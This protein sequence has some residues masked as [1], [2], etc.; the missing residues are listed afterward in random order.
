M[1][2]ITIDFETASQHRRNSACEL[3][4]TFV[5]NNKIIETKSWLIK[6]YINDFDYFN[7]LLHGITAT[8]V[9]NK[10]EFSEIWDEVKELI[11][12]NLLIAH[13]AAFDF[14]VLRHT[15][16]T[17]SLPYPELDYTCSYIFSKK[18]WTNSASFDLQ[19]LCKANNLPRRVHRA[20]PDSEVL[21]QLCLIAFDKM[22]VNCKE[23]IPAKLETTIGKLYSNGYTPATTKRKRNY[24]KLLPPEG[25]PTK[26]DSESIF[27]QQSIVFTGLLSSMSRPE[28]QKIIA[29]IGG[30]N[31]NSVSKKTNFLIVGQQDYRIVGDDGMSNKQERALQLKEQ[32]IEIEIL[33]EEDFLK[34]INY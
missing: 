31:S 11:E 2:F 14:S 12:G 3:G 15:L 13:N 8:H 4:L 20:A 18:I 6:P 30:I 26:F 17:Y 1:K 9:A 21:A 19:T 5:D 10:P 29:D 25:D 28:A 27:Y 32:G 24:E 34:S 33:S 22:G 7:S 16:N 23:D